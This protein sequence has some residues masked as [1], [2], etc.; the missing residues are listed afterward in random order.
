M[1]SLFK[2]IKDDLIGY[3]DRQVDILLPPIVDHTAYPISP[4]GLYR[5]EVHKL[6]A[7]WETTVTINGEDPEQIERFKKI[8][9][10]ALHRDMYK[11]AQDLF[12]K[13]ELAYAEGD[14]QR[15]EKA[16]QELRVEL[17]EV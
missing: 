5:G 7:T 17:F 4:Y 10:Q 2:H 15:L 9:I 3:K 16:L 11:E 12:Y 6:S 8:F 13:V 14:A 1:S